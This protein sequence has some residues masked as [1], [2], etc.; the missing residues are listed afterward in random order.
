MAEDDRELAY[1]RAVEDLFAALRGVPHLL[2]PKD[3]QLLRSW[4]RDEIPLSAIRAGI[5]EVFAR[6]RERGELEHVVSLSYCRHAV[7]AHA[8][9]SAEMHVGAGAESAG[10]SREGLDSALKRLGSQLTAVA[11]RVH[12]EMPLVAETIERIATE[13]GAAIDLPETDVE[14]HLF[15]LESALLGNCLDA[16]G[17]KSRS[18]LEDGAYAKA[19]ETSASPEAR[20]RAFLALRDR[21]LRDLLG[22]PR[23]ELED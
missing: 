15:A 20:D 10:S 18:A 7:K 16:L 14:Q 9:R 2:S 13:V 11:Q 17:E 22:L 23:L 3:F 6:R 5:T 4:W 21:S 8:K 19:K 1:Y 12:D